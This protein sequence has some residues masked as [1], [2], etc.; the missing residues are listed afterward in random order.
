V[1]R[2]PQLFEGLGPGGANRKAVE[3]LEVRS[4]LLSLTRT[5]VKKNRRTHYATI[6]HTDG[7]RTPPPPAPS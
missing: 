4:T 5:A 7:H 2:C 1:L 3:L 6:L